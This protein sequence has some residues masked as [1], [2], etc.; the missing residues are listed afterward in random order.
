MNIRQ[1]IKIIFPDDIYCIR[2]GKI[3]DSTRT[4]SL[5][6]DCIRNFHWTNK[7]TCHK[8]GKLMDEEGVYSLCKDCR[9][10]D[11]YFTQGFTCLMYGLYEKELVLAF[12][13]GKQ[14]YLGEKLGEILKD[15]LEPEFE[16]GLNIDIIIP[17]PIHKKRLRQRGFNQA[18]LMAK[19]LSKAWGLA[20]DNKTLIRTKNTTAMSS[21]DPL[22]RR[23]NIA[24]AFVIDKGQEGGVKDKSILLVDDVYTT[25]STLDECS[26]VL[27]EGGAKDV[28][29]LTLA[30]G[31][32]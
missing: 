11:H 23:S 31:A 21:L 7:K 12:K 30:A 20:F 17:V 2:C 10:M 28:Y 26:R 18:E 32:N 9:N 16:N 1:M 8:C 24:G 15:R 3:I 6:D 29:V 13:Y 22:E 25:G 14:G 5:C 27:L 4:Y 19:P